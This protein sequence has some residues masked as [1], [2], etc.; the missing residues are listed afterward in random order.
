MKRS[1]HIHRFLCAMLCIVML[2]FCLCV[3]TGAD[4]VRKYTV[5]VDHPTGVTAHNMPAIIKN[6]VNGTE[7]TLILAG[8]INTDLTM[9]YYEYTLDGGKTWTKTTD[10]VVSRSDLKKIC[11]NTYQTAGFHVQIDVSGLLRGQYDVFVRGFTSSG[12]VIEAVAMLNVTIGQADIETVHYRELN[13]DALGAKDG[14]IFLPANTPLNLGKHNL[15]EFEGAQIVMDTDAVLTLSA[16]DQSSPFKFNLQTDSATPDENGTFLATLSLI[17]QQYAGEILLT[18]TTDLH[19]LSIR[20]MY[21]TPDYYTDDL[22]IHMT[23]TAYEYLGGANKADAEIQSDDT[24]GTYTHLYPVDVTNDPFIY[25]NIGNYLKETQSIEISADHYRY[26]VITT[27]TPATNS[28]GYF[29]LFLCAGAIRGPSGDSHIAFEAINDGQWHTYVIPLYVE[30]NWTGKIYGIRFDFIDNHAKPTDYANISSIG[31]YPDYESAKAAANMPFEVYHEGGVIPEDKYKEE[32]RAPSG[33]ADAITWFDDSLASC[34]AGENRTQVDF[35]QYGHLILSAT[36]STNDP[37]VTF[38]LQAYAALNE[39]SVLQT[40]DVGV[41]VLRVLA[42]DNISGKNFT[43]YY[44][45]GGMNYAEGTRTAHAEYNGDKWEYLIYDMSEKPY[46]T[47]SILGVRLDFATQINAG[48]K[49]CVSDILFFTD[50]AAWHTYAN[51]NGVIIESESDP[52]TTDTAAPE[53]ERPTIEIPTQGPGLEYIPPAQTE[54]MTEAEGCNGMINTGM[55]LM[56][57]GYALLMLRKRD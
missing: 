38:D 40:K 28:P 32:G 4:T 33:R 25:F 35:D 24:V 18:S 13:S 7:S 21:I 5:T 22:K 49:V 27:Q 34:F 29:R 10:A 51:E 9:E 2:S 44:H 12:D 56:L 26:A 15:R 17:D 47:D 6:H 39:T 1:L 3:V 55:T 54:P 31:F 57:I 52:I 45:S 37:Y 11:P 41:I 16:A 8:W 43:L 14:A 36:E 48:Q 53:T 42:D 20:L 50:M 23:P 46:W 19:V 30:E